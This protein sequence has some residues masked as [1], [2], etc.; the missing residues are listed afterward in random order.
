MRESRTENQ[1]R[2][3]AQASLPCHSEMLKA[4][5]TARTMLLVRS[6]RSRQSRIIHHGVAMTPRNHSTYGRVQSFA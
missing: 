1:A 4:P 2:S 5:A 3:V 6:V